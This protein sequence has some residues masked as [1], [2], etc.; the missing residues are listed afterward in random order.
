MFTSWDR[1]DT[2]HFLIESSLITRALRAR[3][4]PRAFIIALNSVMI[5][6]CRTMHMRIIGRLCAALC[7][8][9]QSLYGQLLTRANG[10]R[11]GLIRCLLSIAAGLYLR[12]FYLACPYAYAYITLRYV[13][14]SY[15]YYYIIG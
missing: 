7:R 9:Q 15:I 6:H 3:R 14:L 11:D 1:F 10:Y 12:V 4:S 8:A 13:T 5:N 2:N